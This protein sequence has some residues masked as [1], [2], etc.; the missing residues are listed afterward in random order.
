MA[1]EFNHTLVNVR[2]KWAA[3]Q[4]VADL[5]GLE[6]PFA[7]GPFAVVTLAHGASLDFIDVE[8]VH[9][10]HSSSTATS[11]RSS[12]GPTAVGTRA[13]CVKRSIDDVDRA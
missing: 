11:W 3:A 8:E 7:Y 1:I 12:P 9:P 2:E 13:C 6:K 4:S 10:Q 5:L